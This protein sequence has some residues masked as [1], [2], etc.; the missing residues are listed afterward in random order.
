MS[1]GSRKEREK[2][3]LLDLDLLERPR[4]QTEPRTAIE[5]KPRSVASLDRPRPKRTRRR[6]Q[7]VTMPTAQITTSLEP[8]QTA[9][10]AAAILLLQLMM[11]GL[12]VLSL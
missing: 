3:M 6:A 1:A 10:G 8:L 2:T 5:F 12:F 4:P 9:F 11:L 7:A